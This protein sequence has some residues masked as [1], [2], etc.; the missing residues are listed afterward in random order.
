VVARYREDRPTSE[1]EWTV[2]RDDI[3]PETYFR[4]G[5]SGAMLYFLRWAGDNRKLIWA[6]PF[7]LAEGRAGG[8]AF[9][10]FE[11]V[12]QRIAP[13]DDEGRIS[14]SA[15]ANRLYFAQTETQTSIWFAEAEK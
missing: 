6:L 12:D 7:Q 9:S 5:P 2:I 4:W 14:I 11:P 15:L 1:S 13:N 3:V 10:L 8:P